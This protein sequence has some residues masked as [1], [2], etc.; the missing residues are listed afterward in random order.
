MKK[1]APASHT[2]ARLIALGAGPVAAVLILTAGLEYWNTI[3]LQRSCAWI[4][5]TNEVLTAI[6][7][8]DS[9]VEEAETNQ[10]GYLITGDE[11]FLE[12]YH[13]AAAAIEDKV[14]R[15][16][17]LTA[18]NPRQQAR[19]R[20]LEEQISA[21]LKE[22]DQAIAARKQ[23]PEGARPIALNR[24]DKNLMDAILRRSRIC[25]RRNGICSWPE[26]DYPGEAT[27][28]PFSRRSSPSPWAWGWSRRSAILCNVIFWSANRPRDCKRGWR[29][30]WN[31]P[32]MQSSRKT[33][34]A[35][36][37]RGMP[38]P[39]VYSATKRRKLSADRSPS[40]C[41]RSGSRRKRRF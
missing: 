23:G 1:T 34:M 25:G 18:D 35:L 4:A 7:G 13:A 33:S 9:T 2:D 12:P 37:R 27:G 21:K 22:L 32:T 19:I 15:L 14:R 11:S 29:R 5:H 24:K 26:S 20:V 41:R 36:S 38:E 17:Q 3:Q 30:S 6:E 39:S 8:A 40:C 31:P 10:R 28:Q 16:K